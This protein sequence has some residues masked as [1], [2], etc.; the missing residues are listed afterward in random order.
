GLA[1]LYLSR[2]I[3]FAYAALGVSSALLKRVRRVQF[4]ALDTTSVALVVSLLAGPLTYLQSQTLAFIDLYFYAGSN[5]PGVPDDSIESAVLCVIYIAT[6]GLLPVAVG[7]LLPHLRRLANAPASIPFDIKA[8]CMLLLATLPVC[9][10]RSR[11]QRASSHLG[12][13]EA[14]GTFHQL[15]LQQPLY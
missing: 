7:L 5:L 9:K 4:S 8:R 15:M 12:T 2:T 1:T 13:M 3:W 11:H 6:I 14:G 10:Q